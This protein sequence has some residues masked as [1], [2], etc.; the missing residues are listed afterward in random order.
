MSLDVAQRAGAARRRF[1]TI[2]TVGLG[3]VL[4]VTMGLVLLRGGDAQAPPLPKTA[5]APVSENTENELGG[6]DQSQGGGSP[7]NSPAP[8]AWVPPARQVTLPAGTGQID[9]L[10]V[11]FPQTPEGAAAAEVAKDRYSSTLDYHLANTVARVY[12][13]PELATTADEASTAAVADLRAKLGV[14]NFGPAPANVSAVTRPLGVQWVADGDDRTEV[15]VLVQINYRTREKAW[16]ELAA[17]STVW[18]WMEGE[19]GRPADWRLVGAHQ[20]EAD[21]AQI[22]TAAF[23]DAGWSAIVTETAR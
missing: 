1:W 17:S 19:G 9:E 13:A 2:A 8:E 12:L 4:L 10:P 5:D 21:L 22:G 3:S 7:E 16:S 23:N 15:S 6:S 14:G 20:P 18:Q 11:G